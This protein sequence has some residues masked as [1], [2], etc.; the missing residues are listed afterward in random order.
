MKKLFQTS[1]LAMALV[2]GSPMA[3]HA[4]SN[5]IQ[6]YE[7]YL[8]IEAEPIAKGYGWSVEREVTEE[9]ELYDACRLYL[10]NN[11]TREQYVLLETKG[12]TISG[13]KIAIKARNKLAY[14]MNE[15][16]MIEH[17]D[18][19]YG[20]IEAVDE[21]FILSPRLIL[22]SGV[23]DGRNVYNYLI[24]LDSYSAVHMPAYG[25]YIQLV[26]YNDKKYL[27]FYTSEYTDRG[28]REIKGWYDAQGNLIKKRNSDKAS[29]F[30]RYRMVFYVYGKGTYCHSNHPSDA[31]HAF[32]YIPQ[33][34]FVGFGSTG[35]HFGGPGN[36]SDHRETRDCATDSCVIYITGEQLESVKAKFREF[37][38]KIPY[39]FF[40]N[41]DCTSFVMNLADAAGIYYGNRLEIQT[42]IYFMEQLKKY[43]D[44]SSSAKQKTKPADAS[45]Q[46]D[47]LGLI[48]RDP[49]ENGYFPKEWTWRIKKDDVHGVS[50]LSRVS[51]HDGETHVTVLLNL[52]HGDLKV[53][54]KE[55]LVYRNSG[56]G[57]VLQSSYTEEISFPA[58][59]NYAHYVNLKMEADIF[60]SLVAYNNSDYRLFVAGDF[61]ENNQTKRF[62]TIVEPHSSSNVMMLGWT[63]NFH[64]HFA[65]KQ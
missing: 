64:I 44:T 31:G 14:G 30:D 42:P 65:Y 29:P 63:D 2:L 23:P 6:R 59:P 22:V 55:V 20:Y 13:T 33:I 26:K 11:E 7:Y 62:A 53:D 61:T 25:P 18:Y 60:P 56:R 45:I 50:E 52:H 43:N 5:K 12:E 15:T 35:D 27:E 19:A 4:I 48:V 47:I 32:V 46:N 34:G 17:P 9:T 8:P 51:S 16:G 10:I 54:V 41:S 38:K 39:Y 40:G 28:R 21:V 36:I 58:Q 49:S 24:D 37:Q 1:I 3:M 57:L